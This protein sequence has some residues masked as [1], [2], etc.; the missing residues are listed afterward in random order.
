MSMQYVQ[1]VLLLLVLAVNSDQFKI[2]VVTHSY[3]SRLFLCAL[4]LLQYRL[5]LSVR[6]GPENSR[7]YM[8]MRRSAGLA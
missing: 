4:A 7:R 1:Y 3:S 8:E 6:R 5:K 2:Y